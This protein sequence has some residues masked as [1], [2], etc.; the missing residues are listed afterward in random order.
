[1]DRD[2]DKVPEGH[3]QP[4]RHSRK[5]EGPDRIKQTARQNGRSIETKTPTRHSRKQ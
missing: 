2:G 1:M 5:D 3:D 4:A